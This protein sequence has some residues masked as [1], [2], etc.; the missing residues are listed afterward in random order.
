MSRIDR[1]LCIQGEVASK[2][3]ETSATITAICVFYVVR[4]NIVIIYLVF[5]VFMYKAQVR[6]KLYSCFKRLSKF[7]MMKQIL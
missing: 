2:G 1:G 4:Q 6:E 5:F 3:L 7:I